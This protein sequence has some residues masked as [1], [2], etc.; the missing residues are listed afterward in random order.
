MAPRNWALSGPV[1]LAI[2]CSE[3]QCQEALAQ[4]EGLTGWVDNLYFPIGKRKVTLTLPSDGP[5][6]SRDEWCVPRSTTPIAG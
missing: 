2:V 4:L 6:V 5:P 3:A 1:L